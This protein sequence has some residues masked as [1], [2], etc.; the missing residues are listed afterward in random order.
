MLPCSLATAAKSSIGRDHSMTGLAI[1][2]GSRLRGG[3][4]E[5]RWANTRYV[6]PKREQTEHDGKAADGEDDAIATVYHDVAPELAAEALRRGR[7]LRHSDAGADAALRSAGQRSWP[8]V[9]RGTWPSCRG[10]AAAWH[11][12][13]VTPAGR[14]LG[15]R[16]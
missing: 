2:G 13:T 9:W 7:P 15:C 8:T 4:P 14:K 11:S 6:A 10:R 12:L 1:A 16:S 3:H 5:D